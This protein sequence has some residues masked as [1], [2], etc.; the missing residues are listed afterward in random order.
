MIE[1]IRVTNSHGMSL[2][3]L[4][5]G[6]A[7]T[8]ILVPDKNG[9][10]ENIVLAY[11]DYNDYI[12]N[13]AYLGVII[14]RTGGRI[15]EAKFELDGTEYSLPKNNNDNTLHGGTGIHTKIW[16]MKQIDNT[17]KLTYFSKDG[18]DGYPGNV[19]IEV[20]YTLTDDNAISIDY[21]A[22]TD[23]A[24]LLN[25]TNHTYFN[26][27]GEAKKDVLSHSLKLNSNFILEIDKFS[28]PTGK[29]INVKDEPTFDFTTKKIIGKDI[30][31][32]ILSETSG[33]DHPF[34]IDK[35]MTQDMVVYSDDVTKR[36]MTMNTTYP[37]VIIYT[38]N[39][40]TQEKLLGGSKY[41]ARY[42]ICFEA[43]NPPIGANECNKEMSILKPNEVYKQNTTYKFGIIGQ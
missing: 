25:L 43:Q 30:N 13:K 37:N 23:K 20:R 2:E 39:S 38:A 4:N 26:L 9:K 8:K 21:T 33:Y 11:Q 40:P 17:I 36:Y 41:N 28:I 10:V 6:G 27:A 3:V 42:G 34:V 12:I 35:D 1:A 14:G 5:I 19:K 32:L 22:T 29:L 15:G 31:D 24:T 16:E 18:D 7:I